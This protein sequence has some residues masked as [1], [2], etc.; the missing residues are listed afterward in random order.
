MPRCETTRDQYGKEA[1]SL[2]SNGN[3]GPIF[4]SPSDP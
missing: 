4:L 2:T 3:K 1:L